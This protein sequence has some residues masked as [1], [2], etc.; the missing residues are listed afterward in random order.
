MGLAE[1]YERRLGAYCFNHPRALAAAR[2][3]VARLRQL[4][5]AY[6]LREGVE[7]AKVMKAFFT[8]DR[9]SAGQ[10]GENLAQPLTVNK[11]FHADGNVRELVTAFY[12]AAYYNT[13][14]EGSSGRISLKHILTSAS[15]S[16]PGSIFGL[17]MNEGSAGRHISHLNGA[18]HMNMELGAKTLRKVTGWPTAEAFKKD[19]FA[20]G[21]LIWMSRPEKVF[22]DTIEMTSSH[23]ALTARTEPDRAGR[24]RTRADFDSSGAP[25]GVYE[26]QFAGSGTEKLPWISGE[27]LW[28]V[29]ADHPWARHQAERGIPTAAGMSGTTMRMMKAFEWINV[30]GVD[31][32]DFRM[33][34]L[35]WMLPSRD[36]SLYEILR[37]SW[38]SGVKGLQE[39]E[40]SASWGAA[41][42]YQNIAPFSEAELRKNVCAGGHF[43][44][45]IIYLESVKKG[46]RG[47]GYREPGKFAARALSVNFEK[48]GREA[49]NPDFKDHERT[50][51]PHFNEAHAA[52]IWTYTSAADRLLNGVTHPRALADRLGPRFGKGYYLDAADKFS[53]KTVRD[54]L[55]TQIRMLRDEN[56]AP[57]LASFAED[58]FLGDL[59]SRVRS[60]PDDAEYQ[61]ILDEA[62]TYITNISPAVHDEMKAHADMLVEALLRLP[63][64]T[65]K[66]YRADWKIGASKGIYKHLGKLS[67][68]YRPGSIHV[69]GF[70]STS[71]DREIAESFIPKQRAGG[72]QH[73]IMLELNLTGK[74]GRDVSLHSSNPNVE[75]EKEVLLLPW[76]QFRIKSSEWRTVKIK[77]AKFHECHEYAVEY[78]VADEI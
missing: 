5:I 33:A 54:I 25:L 22:G 7:P 45:E 9:T 20:L 75:D 69:S 39:G 48:R 76:A 58:P 41:V 2:A 78:V 36:H 44:H 42:M 24:Q 57:I 56:D 16:S 13:G 68:H 34:L 66:C 6:A 26:G 59:A 4:F 23:A 21:G 17:G 49:G 47:G 38:A 27:A 71:R 55:K 14:K 29:A 46:G 67:L 37:G 31:P 53:E 11:L 1:D 52:A 50:P 35:A 8:A 72:M 61:R 73:H 62:D 40:S 10:A 15:G 32:F 43:P 19:P 74:N 28:D 64:S 60:R 12:N 70:T 3:A 65:G 18:A 77:D 63:P 30:P 51:G